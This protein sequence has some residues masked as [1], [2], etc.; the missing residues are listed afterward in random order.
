MKFFT[1]TYYK[2]GMVASGRQSLLSFAHFQ[3]HFVIP[4]FI[5]SHEA[6][7]PTRPNLSTS[8]DVLQR[9]AID[10]TT[11]VPVLFFFTSAAIWL[12]IA[13]VLGMVSSI[14]L[15]APDFCFQVSA[16]GS[17]LLAATCRQT[18]TLDSFRATFLQPLC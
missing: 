6:T 10:K 2:G 18:E 1:S 12:V 13:T 3:S 16:A 4:R 14:K 9:V 11:R 17:P 7:M 8:E 15:F 5:M